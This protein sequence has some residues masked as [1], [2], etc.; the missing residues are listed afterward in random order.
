MPPHVLLLLRALCRQ[1]S[2]LMAKESRNGKRK[3]KTKSRIR[4]MQNVRLARHAD[5]RSAHVS[6]KKV[7]QSK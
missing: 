2:D 1:L 7:R 3:T 6:P 4:K 5:K